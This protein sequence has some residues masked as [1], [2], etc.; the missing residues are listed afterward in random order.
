MAS[1][2]TPNLIL[3]GEEFKDVYE[4]AEDTFLL[5][6]A[7]EKDE[8]QIKSIQPLI[9][10]EVGSG[11][12]C[13]SSFVA[14]MLGSATFY[15]CTDINKKATLMTKTTGIINGNQQLNPVL[16]N[17]AD[18]LDKRLS[19]S[20]D[21]LIFN[22]PYVVTDSLEVKYPDIISKSWAGGIK[23]RE[24]LDKFLPRVENLLSHQGVFYLVAIKP[25]KPDEIVGI[26]SS[27]GF[28]CSTVMERRA[29]IEH[30]L[31]LKFKRK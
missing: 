24:V 18:A 31:I 14:A 11:S 13:V 29:G 10:L 22:P 21:L 23:G 16:T 25:N 2:A 17:F 27:Y 15:I 5:L 12:G 20:V 28:T 19:R 26:M 3:G 6:D 8:L 1:R 9:C 30:L 7:L 4:P